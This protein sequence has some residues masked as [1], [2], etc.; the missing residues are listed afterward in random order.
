M[1]VDT[2]CHLDFKAFESDRDDVVM[3]SISE[4]IGFI[5]NVGSSLEGTRRSIEI[6]ERY[7][8]V[9]AAAGI[10][11]HDADRVK[12]DDLELFKGCFSGNKVVA[13][14][15]IGLDY[16]K[17][18]ASRDNQKR[19]FVKLLE[20]A[21]TRKLPLIIHNRDAH[22][23]IMDIL[24]D[25]MPLPVKGVMHCFSGDKVFLKKCLDMG[26]FISFTCNITFK[27]ASRLR[28]VARLVPADR[29]LLETDAPFLAPQIFRGK[30]NEPCYVK[31]LAEELARMKD[32]SFEEIADITTRNAKELFKFGFHRK[33]H[34][35][36]IS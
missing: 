15:E 18:I 32:L 8:L 5:V 12:Q 25:I 21:K 14:G 27:N 28:E 31:Y 2:H 34:C 1:L 11:P 16:Y 36:P 6:A 26:I 35:V 22:A 19:L 10:H 24:K 30:R 20:E 3:R 4:G 7:D 23:D 33:E 29:L 13:I 9:Y 17:N